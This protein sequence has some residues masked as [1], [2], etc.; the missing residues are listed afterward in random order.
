MLLI[1]AAGLL[2]WPLPETP[3]I[4]IDGTPCE[5]FF[6]VPMTEVESIVEPDRVTGDARREP[7]LFVDVHPP[8]LPI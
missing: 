3:V 2:A 1:V 8:I 7:V 6:N 4:T 5:E